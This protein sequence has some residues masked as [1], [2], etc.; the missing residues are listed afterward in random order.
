MTAQNQVPTAGKEGPDGRAKYLRVKVVDH[1]KAGDPT[2]N[3]RIPIGVVKFGMKM[4]ATF[5]PEMKDVDVDWNA[6][7][8]MIEEGASGE[9]VHVEDE[10]EH[11]TID[12]FVE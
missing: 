8:Q 6:V 12:V 5:S 9:L 1:N 10:T 4:A 7:T 11:K 3:I 2:V